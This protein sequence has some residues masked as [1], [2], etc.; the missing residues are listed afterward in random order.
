MNIDVNLYQK[1]N[2]QTNKNYM[3]QQRVP[4]KS[5][6]RRNN[7]QKMHQRYSNYLTQQMVVNGSKDQQ[8]AAQGHKYRNFN[9]N[10]EADKNSKT[11]QYGQI[12]SDGN[13]F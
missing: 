5:G 6:E 2:T 8:E 7:N 4:S 11:L 12:R 10:L 1:H 3:E 9:S 13:G